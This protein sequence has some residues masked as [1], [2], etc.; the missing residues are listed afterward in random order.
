MHAALHTT[1]MNI[2]VTGASGFVGKALCNALS[3]DGYT[4]NAAVRSEEQAFPLVKNTSYCL[5]GGIDK[6]T[7]WSSVVYGV[8]SIVH[9]AARVHV[10]HDI[11]SDPLSAFRPVNVAGTERLARQ[12]SAAGVRRFIYLSSVKVNGEES[13][14]FYTE[15]STPDPQDAYAV[16]KWEAEQILHQVASATGMEVLLSDHRLSMVLV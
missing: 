8:D 9:L 11:A 13:P 14:V 7:D 16:S 15:K 3:N 2:L 4:I 1:G 6:D 5:V 10:M 12:A